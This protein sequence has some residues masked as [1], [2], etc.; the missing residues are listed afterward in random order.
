MAGHNKIGS[1]VR[2]VFQYSLTMALL[3]KGLEEYRIGFCF[4]LAVQ[5]I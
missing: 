2:G 4:G 5:E 1:C 3:W